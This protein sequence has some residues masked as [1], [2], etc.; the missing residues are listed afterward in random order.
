MC[1]YPKMRYFKCVCQWMSSIS[2]KYTGNVQ[3]KNTVRLHYN[4]MFGVLEC[5]LSHEWIMDNNNILWIN[6][7]GAT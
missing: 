4:K 3:L 6:G 2:G 7:G 1:T 5:E